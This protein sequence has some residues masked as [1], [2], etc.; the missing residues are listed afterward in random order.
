MK[1]KYKVLILLGIFVAGLAIGR[2]GLPAKVEIKT[3]EKIVE[4]VVTKEVEKKNREDRKN[5]TVVIIE[6]KMPDGTVRK[7]TRIV[8]KGVVEL[9]YSKNKDSQSET[10][11]EKT[12]EKTTTYAKNDWALSVLGGADLGQSWKTPTMVYGAHAQ[13]RV[14]GPFYMGAFGL[15]SKT[16]GGSLGVLF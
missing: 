11:T 13:R 9:D 15:S 6:T 10:E 16:F 3:Q 7:E 14:L 8:D 12:E 5:K 2:F 4:K 1:T